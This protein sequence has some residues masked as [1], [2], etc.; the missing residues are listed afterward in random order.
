M[1]TLARRTASARARADIN[2]CVDD[3]S[4]R[5]RVDGVEVAM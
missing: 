2:R 4:S 3:A 5:R 1:I